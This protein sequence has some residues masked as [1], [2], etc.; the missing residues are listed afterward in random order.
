MSIKEIYA[1]ADNPSVLKKAYKA[2]I[3]RRERICNRCPYHS[4]EN[5]YRKRKDRRNWKRFRKTQ[6]K[7][8]E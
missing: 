4:G 3:T 1:T 5:A 8:K 6:W 2:F 7:C